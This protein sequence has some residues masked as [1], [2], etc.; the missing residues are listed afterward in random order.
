[1]AAL[2]NGFVVLSCPVNDT[3]GPCCLWWWDG[4]DQ[5]PGKGR[6]VR[7]AVMLGSVSTTGGASAEGLALRK[8]TDAHAD[9]V[10]VYKTNTAAQAVSM[11]VMLP[12]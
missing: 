12:D 2:K 3:P 8:Q 9:L 6:K 1:M 10:V 11:R 5:V 7:E 4:A